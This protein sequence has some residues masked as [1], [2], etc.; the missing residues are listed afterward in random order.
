[1]LQDWEHH[2]GFIYANN[3]PLLMMMMMIIFGG[4]GAELNPHCAN[5]PC[6]GLSQCNLR[7]ELVQTLLCA[8]LSAYGRSLI[9]H[10]NIY[11]YKYISNISL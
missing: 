9:L 8:D 2:S 3:K 5:H 7:D 1:M 10:Q 11:P 4:G 6:A